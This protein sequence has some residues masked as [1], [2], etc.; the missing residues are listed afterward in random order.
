MVRAFVADMLSTG[1]HSP[2]TV[3]KVGQILAKIMPR[4]SQ[5]RADC[6]LALRRRPAAH[7]SAT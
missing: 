4:R 2:A 5:R 3:R 6:S 1:E 7:G